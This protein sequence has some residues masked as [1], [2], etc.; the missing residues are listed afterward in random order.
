MLYYALKAAE[1]LLAAYDPTAATLAPTLAARHTAPDPV[2]VPL[3]DAID[4][5]VA[6][7]P[8]VA[9]KAAPL[10]PDQSPPAPPA[11]GD[12]AD[13]AAPARLDARTLTT[14]QVLLVRY[15]RRQAVRALAKVRFDVV[16]GGTLPL[17][18][19]AWTLARVAVSDVTISPPPTASEVG[20]AV[21]GLAGMAPSANLNV[22]EWAVVMAYGLSSF[23]RPKLAEAT[24]KSAAWKLTGARLVNAM[25]ALKRSIPG[26]AR[27][28]PY[29]SPLTAL[30]DTATANLLAPLERDDPA[31]RP[32]ID[33]INAWIEQNL[34]KDPNRS[35]YKDDPKLKLAPRP[36]GA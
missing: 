13:P 8:P 20:E 34:P 24:D 14:E 1:G 29:Q 9:D 25:A 15:F 5:L 7:G 22:D 33:P 18:R 36:P 4:K 28:R 23:A 3:V 2:L 12:P 21:I 27:L 17:V 16:G 26:N 10:N 19:P 31:A 35:L 32:N 30:I 11:A 6:N